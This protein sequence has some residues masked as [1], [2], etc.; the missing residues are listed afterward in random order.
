MEQPEAGRTGR[1][2]RQGLVL[3]LGAPLGWAAVSTVLDLWDRVD[4]GFQ[5]L[6]YAYMTC[7]AML[8]FAIFGYLMG[9]QEQRFAELS[10]V[11]HLTRV[12]NTRYFHETLRT[13]FANAKRYGE[14]MCLILLDL[15]HFKSV[16][17]TYGH[18]AG[19]AVLRTLAGTMGK[20]VREG[21]TLARVGGEEFAVIM[22]HTDSKGGETLAER[23]RLAVREK[24]IALP[25][26]QAIHI[27]VSL[28]VAGLDH[29]EADSSTELFARVDEALYAAKQGGR[30]RVVVAGTGT[31]AACPLNENQD[32]GSC[33]PS[34][35]ATAN[36]EA[37][38]EMEKMK[39]AFGAHDDEGDLE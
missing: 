38:E 8:V 11:D 6:L 14:S 10:L 31:P 22:P 26:G 2:L 19:D 15:D 20:L 3:G 29:V 16:N 17:D 28:G 7:G 25:E 13:E 32:N 5:I 1:R 34:A 37:A 35:T 12:Y 9:R 4:S 33:R 18:P 27:R 39:R 30:D 24:P 36:A 21:D 23:I